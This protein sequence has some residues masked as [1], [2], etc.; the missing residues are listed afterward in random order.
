MV[1]R[2]KKREKLIEKYSERRKALK[3]IIKKSDDH[4]EIMDAQAKLAKLPVNSNPVRLTNRCQICGRTHAV[5][6]KVEI[7]RICFR[8]QTMA[9]NVPGIRKSSW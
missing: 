7:C 4:N 1:A 6:S 2:E 9:G 3:Q 8:E 5:Y